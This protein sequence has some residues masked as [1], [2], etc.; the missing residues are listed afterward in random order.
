MKAQDQLEQN[1]ALAERWHYDIC[2]V[3]NFKVA[4]EILAHD[5][6]LHSNGQDT[7]GLEQVKTMIEGFKDLSNLK[8]DHP[9]IIAEGNL[10]MILWDASADNTKDFMGIPATGKNIKWAGI[11]LFLIED[12]KI[13]EVWQYYDQLGFMSQLGMEL[14]MKEA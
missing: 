3:M 13:K 7:I 9:Q 11:D 2:I 14:K 4:D 6:A 5:I 12:G 10:V 8:V 1:K